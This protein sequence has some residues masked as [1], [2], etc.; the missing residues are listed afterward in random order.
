MTHYV[1]ID[2]EIVLGNGLV[3]PDEGSPELMGPF[4][5]NNEQIEWLIADLAAVNRTVTPWYV[6]AFRE[7]TSNNSQPQPDMRAPHIVAQ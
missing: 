2:T 1:H 7:P 3:G 6:E 5:S 4:G